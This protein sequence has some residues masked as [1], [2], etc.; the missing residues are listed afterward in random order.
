[1]PNQAGLLLF[2]L[3]A[4]DDRRKIIVGGAVN[5]NYSTEEPSGVIRAFDIDTGALVWNWDS[6]NP[7]RDDADRRRARPTPPTRP[8][9]GRSS[10]VDETLG[11]IYVPL[12]NQTPDQLGG[13]RSANVEK[14][15]SSI[16]AL[17]LATGQVRWVRQTRA[18]RSLG[19]GRAG[20]A[21]R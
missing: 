1:M 18:S 4:G 8:T 11:L 16:V 17:D 6:G 7:G 5:D 13:G 2:D 20:A 15:S 3:A 19:H 14:F 21:E 10:S 12:G 9:A